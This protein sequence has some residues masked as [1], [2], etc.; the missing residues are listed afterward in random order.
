MKQYTTSLTWLFSFAVFFSLMFYSCEVGPAE[1]IDDEETVDICAYDVDPICFCVENP[2]DPRCETCEYEEDPECFCEENPTAI[3]CLQCTFAEDPD[4]YCGDNPDDPQCVARELEAFNANPFTYCHNNPESNFCN[5][6]IIVKAD[7]EGEDVVTGVIGAGGSI[8]SMGGSPNANTIEFNGNNNYGIYELIDG[9]AEGAE[10]VALKV[11]T[12][13]APANFWEYEFIMNMTNVTPGK[14]YLLIGR[15][16][17]DRDGRVLKLASGLG[18]DPCFVDNVGNAYAVPMQEGWNTFGAYAQLPDVGICDNNSSY[19]PLTNTQFRIILGM[20]YAEN[21]PSSEGATDGAVFVIDYLKAIE[22][23]DWV[24][25]NTDP[26]L[27]C[28]LYPND[29]FCN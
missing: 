15:V 14:R 24:D 8:G 1:I 5:P 13:E 6:N 12:I 25:R 22:V 10:G 28:E 16:K 17:C 2:N 4:C 7:F 11:T 18:P 9:A 26:D 3:E 20:G 27:F 23:G 19:N 29:G 21:Y